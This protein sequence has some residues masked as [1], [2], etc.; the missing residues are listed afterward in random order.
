[1]SFRKEEKIETTFYQQKLLL[2]KIIK[3][4]G[5]LL[6]P[7]RKISSIYFDSKNFEM[8]N[9][10]EEGILPRKK[11]RIRYYN[12]NQENSNLEYK[13]SSFEGKY[14]TTNK[15]NLKLLNRYLR[16]GC[17]DQKYGF[18][19]PII[20]ITYDRRY[21]TLN[22]VRITFDDNINYQIFNSKI[23]ILDEVGVVELKSKTDKEIE[24]ID[25][26][27]PLA[28]KRFSKFSRAFSYLNI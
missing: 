22:N 9:E 23:K 26:I 15:L 12:N 28:R 4:G 16:E 20:K 14:K 21:Y 24:D 18:C 3:L 8:H 13:I 1:M 19:Y 5:K 7:S 2:D 10:S 11:I 17:V 6:Y 25:K 27:L